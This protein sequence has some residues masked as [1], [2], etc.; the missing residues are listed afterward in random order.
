MTTDN[1]ANVGTATATDE[2]NIFARGGAS[3]FT[4]GSIAAMYIFNSALS[5]D[6]LTNMKNYIASRFALT[7]S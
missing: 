7:I 1:S 3:L 6:D 4:T 5:G 2:F